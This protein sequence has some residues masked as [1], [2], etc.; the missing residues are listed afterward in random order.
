M[1]FCEA[2]DRSIQTEVVTPSIEIFRLP[3]EFSLTDAACDVSVEIT[4]Q[5]PLDKFHTNCPS[6]RIP[7]I[8][9]PDDLQL[10]EVLIVPIVAFANE[11]GAR[12]RYVRD[13]RFDISLLAPS[14]DDLNVKVS[15]RRGEGECKKPDLNSRRSASRH[16]H[17]CLD[18]RVL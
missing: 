6:I 11:N 7:V 13:D 2:E 10:A 4:L 18:P 9:S 16:L 3:E 15:P 14:I 8:Q 5:G 12:S 17:N 1:F